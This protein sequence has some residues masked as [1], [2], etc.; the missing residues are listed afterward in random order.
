MPT[1]DRPVDDVARSPPI[2]RSSFA[3]ASVRINVI[4]APG[5]RRLGVAVHGV[6]VAAHRCGV[7]LAITSSVPGRSGAQ[8]R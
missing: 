6:V 3:P 8:L 1:F 4:G 7:G 5:R 2:P